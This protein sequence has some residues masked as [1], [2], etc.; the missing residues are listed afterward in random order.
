MSKRGRTRSKKRTTKPPILNQDPLDVNILHQSDQTKPSSSSSVLQKFST[1]FL[2]I[3]YPKSVRDGYIEYQMWDVVQGLTSYLRGQLAYQSM[4]VGLGV[5]DVEASATVGVLQKIIRD[6]TSMVGSL[7]F[8]YFYS[9]EFGY[10]VRQW[11]LFADV[12]ND[13]GLT[14]H[15]VAPLAG[16]ENF[17]TIACIASLL[18]TLCGIS[19]GATK[20]YISSHFALDNNLTDLVAK[21]GSQ[22]TAVNILGLVGGY[23]MVA[24]LGNIEQGANTVW[25][26]FILLTILHVVA[27]IYAIHY[28]TFNY[29][30]L[31]RFNI[32]LNNFVNSKYRV[33]SKETYHEICRQE[34]FLPNIC[35]ASKQERNCVVLGSNHNLI[36]RKDVHTFTQGLIFPL[37]SNG[38]RTRNKNAKFVILQDKTS[39]LM[40]VLLHEK[41]TH[42]DI[43]RGMYEAHAIKRFGYNYFYKSTT[44]SENKEQVYITFEE[45]QKTLHAQQ[46]NLKNTNFKINTVRYSSFV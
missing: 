40:H 15:F 7:L 10:D 2:P 1:L 39:E 4:L 41:A 22:E 34:P 24:S 13:L 11:R 16:K 28:L 18:T 33:E 3:N 21:E 29:L 32:C 9:D 20:A 46:W 30:N 37:N 35:C 36:E 27:N 42:Q 5:G 8:T 45:F 14:L 31:Q 38:T 43:L 12:S 26:S 17:V 23:L 44:V 6:T 19:A 25:I